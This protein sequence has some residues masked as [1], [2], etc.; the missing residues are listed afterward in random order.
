MQIVFLGDCSLEM[1]NP[2][3]GETIKKNLI[4]LSSVE[5]AHSVVIILK[6]LCEKKVLQNDAFPEQGFIYFTLSSDYL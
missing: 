2:N 3:Y 4:N 6:C 1:S 5:A